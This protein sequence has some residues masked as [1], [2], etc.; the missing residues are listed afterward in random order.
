MI[1]ENTHPVKPDRVP[2]VAMES[3]LR[4]EEASRQRP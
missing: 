4:E 3:W 2:A 1:A